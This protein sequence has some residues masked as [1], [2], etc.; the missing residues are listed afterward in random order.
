MYRILFL[1]L[2]LISISCSRYYEPPPQNL[3]LLSRRAEMQFS[4][5]LSIYGG[6]VGCAF[7]PVKHLGINANAWQAFTKAKLGYGELALG[8]YHGFHNQ[9]NFEV[10]GGYGRGAS[11]MNDTINNFFLRG[12]YY[13]G[14]GDFNNYFIQCNFGVD[15][16]SSV[17][18]AAGARYVVMD[19]MASVIQKNGV[20]H[21]DAS[22]PGKGLE[23]SGLMRIGKRHIFGQCG[24][25]ISF[26]R[27]DDPADMFRLSPL[28]IF[29]GMLIKF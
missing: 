21:Y 29:V 28:Q 24:G 1:L 9:L 15:L 6:S 25:T 17:F 11:S 14:K 27:V 22:F 5:S 18:V 20:T 12:D 7:S 3:P 23:F 10:Y 8:Y 26:M 13:H 2:A 19:Y 4:P 16:D